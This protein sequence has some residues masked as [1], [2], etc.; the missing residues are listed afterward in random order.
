M[1][2]TPCAP[3]VFRGRGTLKTNR[4]VG[5][6]LTFVCVMMAGAAL[7]SPRPALASDRPEPVGPPI[8]NN[9]YKTRIETGRQGVDVDDYVGDFAAGDRLSVTVRS[10]FQSAL[11]PDL[12]ILDPDGIDRTSE[13]TTGGRFGDKRLKL[14]R[15]PIDKSGRWT[16]RI[17][18][19]LKTQGTYT[20]TFKVQPAPKQKS[21]DLVLGGDEPLERVHA[22]EAV[23]GS[24]LDVTVK[25][26]KRAPP[27]EIV[28]V[29]APT[30][31]EVLTSVGTSAGALAR[32]GR[33]G[34]A[35]KK[36]PLTNGS[37]TYGIR[38]RAP[39]GATS[40]SIA[41]RVRAPK[42]P[43]GT[44][45]LS[46][47]EPHIL[48][49]A[50]GLLSSVEGL[51][52]RIQGWDFS[53]GVAPIVLFG[54]V[55]G[56]DVLVDGSGG[57]LD[58][59]VPAGVDDTRV[60]LTVI[61]PDD[62]G[63]VAPDYFYYVPP[64][65][66]T[67]VTD[68]DDNPLSG[69]DAEGGQLVRIHGENLVT[70]Q[71]V[72]FGEA[73]E[74]IP[75]LRGDVFEVRTPQKPPGK[76]RVRI[77]DAYEHEAES[78]LEFEFKAA[79][80]LA[81]EAYTPAVATAHSTTDML[82]RGAN[83]EPTDR[84]FFDGGEISFTLLS[85][86]ILRLEIPVREDG[87]YPIEI[88]DRFG[89]GGLGPELRVKAPG[90]VDDV[91]AVDGPRAG[92]SASEIS[93]HGG[94]VVRVSGSG[95][96]RHDDVRIGAA[97]LT[98][99]AAEATRL[100]VT[101]TAAA[102]GLV[103]VVVIDAAGQSTTVADGVRY[104]GFSDATSSRTPNR[105]SIEDLSAE[106]GAVGDLDGDGDIDDLVIVSHDSSPGT[107]TERT[108]LFI[109]GTGRRLADRTAANLPSTGSD[110]SGLDDWRAHAV[111]LADLDPLD[112][113]GPEILLAGS[114]PDATVTGELRV[115]RNDGEGVFTLDEDIVPPSTS[116]DAVTAQDEDGT[117]HTVFGARAVMGAPT[118][119]AIGDLDSDGDLDVVIGRSSYEARFFGVDEA[120]VNF[121]AT[122]PYVSFDAA[123]ANLLD[124]T[125]YY[126]GTRIL[127]NDLSG[128]GKFV[129]V[130]GAALPDV[131]D[132]DTLTLPAFHATD[133]ALADLDDD[134]DLDLV[135]TWDDPTTVTAYG[136]SQGSGSDSARIA[137]RVLLN[138]GT[139]VFTDATATWMPTVTAPE[140]YQATRLVVVDLDDNGYPD[141]VLV[142]ESSVDAYQG[143]PGHN[144]YA[145]RVLSNDGSAFTDVT[146]ASL[147]ALPTTNDDNLRADAL[148]VGDVDGDGVPDI[149][150]G[151]VVPIRKNVGGALRSTRLLLGTA[152][153]ISFRASSG[154]LPPL[155]DDSGEANELLFLPD[156][157]GNDRASLILISET[158]P[159]KSRGT[160]FLRVFDW[161]R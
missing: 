77:T 23:D 143:P 118:A 19:A 85:E 14:T 117:V 154:F 40:Y 160:S 46:P 28:S 16:V 153:E 83:F 146:A 112:A 86:F 84:V 139:G 148:V 53:V 4:L 27:V 22:L 6:I 120:A 158:L 96:D 12:R 18:A 113:N 108:R 24:T 140:F 54:D 110:A 42:R 129:D 89:L 106:R 43:K 69:G 49:P 9:Q 79:P 73:P 25:W 95:F 44:R 88:R 52:V 74:L 57:F 31:D 66:I 15:F 127:D 90:I 76:L 121:D 26:P 92:A 61:N 37:G 122:P 100:D 8:G 50:L 10:P 11:R 80:R 152:S 161:E 133:L 126:A 2:A 97:V 93:I 21:T 33:R 60:A 39:A 87:L 131:G 141:L 138:D 132:S 56:T 135:V 81:T 58:V 48:P 38:V 59:V 98:P 17:A 128:A 144:R 64:P 68:A 29:E 123:S 151:S 119:I 67:A 71:I 104:V 149:V 102:A 3:F 45:K 125:R 147:P 91:R 72:L 157:A 62:Q 107:R 115:L 137:T 136:L 36:F 20:V 70:G 130:S 142:H 145:L 78:P 99:S 111:A 159:T 116:A 5:A 82:L 47:V 105:T 1:S 134:G 114:P 103:D 34:T 32:T 30:G 35:F 7:L 65:R 51:R 55:R 63:S 156:L 41:W 75:I 13:A 150:L 124:V 109:G 101:A 94:S 155:T